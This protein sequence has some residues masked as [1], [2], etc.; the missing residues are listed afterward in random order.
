MACIA[1]QLPKALCTG[2]HMQHVAEPLAA[3]TAV[4]SATSVRTC[5]LNDAEQKTHKP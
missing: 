2:W 3:L 5:M 1:L 4:H